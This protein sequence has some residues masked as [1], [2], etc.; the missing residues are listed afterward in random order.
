MMQ[1]NILLTTTTLARPGTSRGILFSTSTSSLFIPFT[2]F[3]IFST[4]FSSFLSHISDS[5][6]TPVTHFHLHKHVPTRVALSTPGYT[7]SHYVSFKSYAKTHT[8][9]LPNRTASNIGLS[10]FIGQLHTFAALYHI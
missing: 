4:Y 2:S 1:N 3:Q 8:H 6:I 10:L 9:R 7:C 5:F